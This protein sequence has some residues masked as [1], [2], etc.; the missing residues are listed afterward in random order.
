MDTLN[1]NIVGGQPVKV[2]K[3]CYHNGMRGVV[4][5]VSKVTDTVLVKFPHYR[6]GHGAHG[7]EWYFS[8]KD[9]ILI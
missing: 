9:L 5:T 4:R 7:D 2:I 6:D 1:K 3:E 8:H